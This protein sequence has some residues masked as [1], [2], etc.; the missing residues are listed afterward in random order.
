M[1]IMNI[2]KLALKISIPM[3][4]SMLAIALYGIV[5]TA[6]VSKISDDALTT[7][8]L[9]VPMQAIITAISLGI[10]IGVNSNLAKSLGQKA[11][12]KVTKII[13][14]G[15]IFSAVSWIIIAIICYFGTKTFF[16]FFTN[17]ETIIGLGYDY[18]SIIG[19]FSIGSIFQILFEKILEAYGKAKTSMLV[20][21]SGTIVN[22][23]LDPIL[24]FGLLGAPVL[25]IRGAAIATV[26]GQTI[27]MIIGLISLIKNRI[28]KFNYLVN[29][30]ADKEIISGIL[31]VGF[32]T[33]ILEAVTSF[34]AL[35]LNKILITFSESA[36]SVWGIYYQLQR[37][38]FIIIYGMNYGMIPIVAYNL[39][40]KQK[41]RVEQAI[42]FFLQLAIGVA[43]IG[44]LLFLLIPG[45]LIN[46]FDITQEVYNIAVPAF[47]ILSLGFS[48][49][50]VA[51]VISATFQAFGNGMYSLIV[52]LLRKLIFVVPIIFILKSFIGIY[53]IW[54]A[55]TV[56]EII[57]MLI[58]IW[59]FRKISRN[60]IEK[61]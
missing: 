45:Q 35:F 52:N 57:T 33:M 32:P 61:I 17:N 56:A 54:I 11:E 19:I 21:F 2:K 34:I 47:R 1:E 42:K 55:F 40:A 24:I 13:S 46:F 14:Y 4:I 9:A 58:A 37:F 59:L 41:T 39:G 18:F 20:Q 60:I 10:G 49:A 50:A 5:D 3:I 8:S 30:S 7:V 43:V 51:L 53:S 25:G 29:I 48:F 36:V 16:S 28:F 27:G 38:I 23:I 31:K 44:E 22:L 12:K 26:I 15:C 6:F